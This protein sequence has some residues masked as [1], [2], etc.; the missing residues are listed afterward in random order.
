VLDHYSSINVRV[1]L[2]HLCAI[3]SKIRCWIDSVAC[4]ELSML[5]AI[6]TGTKGRG[7]IG[8][9]LRPASHAPVKVAPILW[10]QL[11]G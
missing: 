8:P 5:N 2:Q 11:C 9:L 4:H 10:G 6:D 7:W 1:R 3:Q